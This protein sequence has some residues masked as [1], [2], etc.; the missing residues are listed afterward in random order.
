MEKEAIDNRFPTAYI[1]AAVEQSY[2]QSREE[3]ACLVM[4]EGTEPST[5]C[6][7]HQSDPVQMMCLTLVSSLQ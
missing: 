7:E 4:I 3:S 2:T 1:L 5:Q 6:Q